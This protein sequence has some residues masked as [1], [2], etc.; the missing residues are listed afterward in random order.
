M[1][2]LSSTEDGRLSEAQILKAL[3]QP[4]SLLVDIT[5]TTEQIHNFH[6]ALANILGADSPASRNVQAWIPHIFLSAMVCESRVTAKKDILSMILFIIDL[7]VQTHLHSGMV[8]E[9]AVDVN[10]TC[11][12]FSASHA[13]VLNYILFVNLPKYLR[14]SVKRPGEESQAGPSGN[15]MTPSSVPRSDKEEGR[16][17]QGTK[18]RVRNK[19]VKQELIVVADKFNKTPKSPKA[20]PERKQRGYMYEA[21]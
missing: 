19:Q 12:D 21:S 14:G 2:H 1:L 9:D 20:L 16:E 10:I 13:A 11:L 3:T 17:N 18:M 7:A 4:C 5:R 6:G 8:C 15:R